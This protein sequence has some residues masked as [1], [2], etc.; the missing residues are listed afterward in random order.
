ML[1]SLCLCGAAPLV[2]SLDSYVNRKI[3]ANLPTS[4][5][6]SILGNGYASFI[7]TSLVCGNPWRTFSCHPF[8]LQPWQ[9]ADGLFDSI[10]TILSYILFDHLSPSTYDRDPCQ[11]GCFNFCCISICTLSFSTPVL[12]ISPSF[13]EKIEAYRY[14][15]RS[16][17]TS[18]VDQ[19]SYL[20]LL[21]YS[22]LPDA[23]ENGNFWHISVF[24]CRL[25]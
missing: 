24:F 1:T 6:S 3:N 8:S 25:H 14:L 21:A 10:N 13:S 7:M 15:F 9:L 12:P 23:H 19:Y 4:R 5:D 22:S 11:S 20:Q 17:A 16:L 2:S 18:F